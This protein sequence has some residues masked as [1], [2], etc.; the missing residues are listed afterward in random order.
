MSFLSRA[1]EVQD[2]PESQHQGRHPA[3][4]REPHTVFLLLEGGSACHPNASQ[5]LIPLPD[6]LVEGVDLVLYA[7]LE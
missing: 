2:K 7:P 5:L 6:P 4:H 3:E 1:S